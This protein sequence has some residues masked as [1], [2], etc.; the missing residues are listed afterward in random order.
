VPVK[1][2]RYNSTIGTAG[3]S[4]PARLAR[5]RAAV[6]PLGAGGRSRVSGLASRLLLDGLSMKHE[7]EATVVW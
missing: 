7:A 3:S 2:W 6:S 1:R 5:G 4:Y